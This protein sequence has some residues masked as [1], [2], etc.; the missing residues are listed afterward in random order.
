MSIL[1]QLGAF[2]VGEA[3]F[4]G[5]CAT[6]L[7]RFCLCWYQALSP[8]VTLC[9]WWI[10]YPLIESWVHLISAG[11]EHSW[12]KPL[13][14]THHLKPLACL[15][16]LSVTAVST[17]E[18]CCLGAGRAVAASE[19]ASTSLHISANSLQ[20]SAARHMVI[21]SF[22]EEHVCLCAWK[23]IRAA[24]HRLR[25]IWRYSPLPCLLPRESA[26]MASLRDV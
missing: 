9:K 6:E 18:L 21:R 8:T 22:R 3:S 20:T 7:I 5:S 24:C 4:T 15:L 1:K 16:G 25:K 13:F 26:L 14:L 11:L 19:V 10:L 23:L 12:R 2:L 17:H